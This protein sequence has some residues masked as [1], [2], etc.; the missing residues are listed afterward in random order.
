V[1]NQPRQQTAAVVPVS[2]QRAAEHAAG[3]LCGLPAV[4]VPCGFSR[5]K[6]PL[7]LLFVGRALEGNVLA[8]ARLFQGRTDWHAR[9]PPVG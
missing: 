1:G 5:E 8:A 7:G 9:R 3:N 2:S 6:L 4:G